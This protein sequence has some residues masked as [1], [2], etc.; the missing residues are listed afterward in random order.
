MMVIIGMEIPEKN[1]SISIIYTEEL[2]NEWQYYQIIAK[3]LT[4]GCRGRGECY[5]KIARVVTFIW[6]H[7]FARIGEDWV[8]LA[9][10]GIIMALV[11]FAMDYSISICNQARLWLVKDLV[12]NIWLQFLAWVSLPVFLVL[13]ATGFVHVVAPQAIGSGIPEMKTILRG[14]VLKEYLTFR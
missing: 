3:P 12:S 4:I 8:F 5:Q 14:V 11:S 6:K 13:F 10:L 1:V 2:Q 7:T 9:L